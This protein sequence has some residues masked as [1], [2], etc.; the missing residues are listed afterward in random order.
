MKRTFFVILVSW[1]TLFYSCTTNGTNW[2]VDAYAPVVETTMDLTNMIG[3]DNVQVNGDSSMWLNVDVNA[4]TFELDTLAQLPNLEILYTYAWPFTTPGTLTAGITLPTFEIPIDLSGSNFELRESTIK[5]GHLQLDVKSTNSERLVLNYTIPDATLGG[6]P[7]TFTDTVRG[8]NP[9]EDTVINHFDFNVAGYKLITTGPNHN[10]HSK[11]SAYLTVSSI[12]GDA[13]MPIAGSQV[14]FRVNNKMVDIIPL[15]GKGYLGQLDL[16]QNNITANLEVMQMFKS[17]VVDIEQLS[18]GLTI[19]NYIGA[20]LRFKPT[21]LKV[22]NSNSGTFL[23]LIHSSM[24][25]T[26]NLSR[27][28][29]TG[30]NANPVNPYIYTYNI[31]SG[32]SNIESMVEL[33]PDKI[34]F[35]ATMQL[36]PYGNISGYNDFYY[37]DYPAYI[38]MQLQAPLKFSINNLLMVDTLDNP[39]STL[40]ILNNIQD[41]QFI[42]RAENKF[43][44]EAKLQIYTLNDIGT[45][46]DS[47]MVNDIIAAAPVNA[48]DRV[49]T[50][51]TSELIASVVPTKITHLHNAKKI[52]LKAFFNTLPSSSG[53]MQMYSD[54]YLKIKLIADIKYNIEL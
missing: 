51:V 39:F 44:L 5:S 52:K 3:A 54:Y 36:N 16:S 15:Y 41:G 13:N 19:Y 12:A 21:V 4:F 24:G 22:E 34:D 1:A 43:P 37:T 49:T 53:R 10:E 42:I 40:D 32:N 46:T 7:F 8:L 47:I 50:P 2:D 30:N 6:N 23:N 28:Y 27:A 17:G 31:N 45:I 20:D 38:R 18:L 26:V 33:L 48:M 29:E 14:L 25:N 11:F 35:S 9:G